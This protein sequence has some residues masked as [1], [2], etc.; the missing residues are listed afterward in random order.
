MGA[1]EGWGEED[2]D[3]LAGEREDVRDMLSE[4]QGV[5]SQCLSLEV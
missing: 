4:K 3:G 1:G 2:E 5:V